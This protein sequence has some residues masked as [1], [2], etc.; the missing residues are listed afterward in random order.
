MTG[1][2]GYGYKNFFNAEIRLVQA[3]YSVI[4]PARLNSAGDKWDVCLRNDIKHIVK[5]CSGMAVLRNWRHSRGARLEVATA[6][7]LGM[8]I[9]D[10]ISLRPL[11]ITLE[12]TFKQRRI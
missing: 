1:L 12:Q 5:Y 2:P 3:G 11:E 10:A 4:N 6:I 8:F 9:I 7:Q